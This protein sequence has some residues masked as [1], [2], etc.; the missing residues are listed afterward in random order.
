[1]K[2]VYCVAELYNAGGIGRIITT[3]ANYLVEKGHEVCLITAEQARRPNFYQL[4]SRVKCY[5]MGINYSENRTILGKT[6]AYLSKKKKHEQRLVSLLDLIKPDIT[7]STMGNE[8]FFLYKLKD[9]SKKILEIHFARN[10]RLAEKRSFIWNLVDMYRTWQEDKIIDKYSRFITL[11]D[12]DRKNWIGNNIVTIP[13]IVNPSKERKASLMEKR[14]IAVGRLVFIKGY[15]RLIDA[16]A[17]VYEQCPDWKLDIYGNGNLEENLKS[18]I[19]QLGLEEVIQIHNPVSNIEEKY[20]TS[21]GLILTSIHEGFGLVLVEAMAYGVPVISF[22]CPCGPRDIIDNNID[23]I[24]VTEG[25]VQGLASAIIKLI[26]N[27]VYRKQLGDAAFQKA[28]KYSADTVMNK[29]IQLFEQVL[30][31]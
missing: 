1:M 23:G 18:Q 31:E 15:D 2:I 22:A 3:K 27:D 10:Y 28:H 21:S 12:E 4:D 13:N 11:T 19:M 14:L 8:A 26:K 30:D 6:F 5:D 9:R 29:W 20:V 17:L 7:I 16:W 25:D 24:L